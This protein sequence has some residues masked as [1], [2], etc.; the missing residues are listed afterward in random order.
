MGILVAL[1][2]F[3][4]NLHL[5]QNFCINKHVGCITTM[6]TIKLGGEVALLTHNQRLAASYLY[7]VE[8]SGEIDSDLNYVGLVESMNNTYNPY[9]GW[10]FWEKTLNGQNTLSD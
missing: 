6:S 3:N 1:L 5:N 7:C 4:C 10:N 8:T 9:S 2:M